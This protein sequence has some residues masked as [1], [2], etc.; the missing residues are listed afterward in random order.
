MNDIKFSDRLRRVMIYSKEEA[1]RLGNPTLAP[2]HLLLGM[3]RDG[4]NGDSV[5][6]KSVV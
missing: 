6:R 4:E 2:E 3:L 1:G 5:D